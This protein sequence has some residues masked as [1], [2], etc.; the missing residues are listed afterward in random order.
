M[1]TL[2]QNPDLVRGEAARR[3]RE[4]LQ[5]VWNFLSGNRDAQFLIQGEHFT[6]RFKNG[7]IYMGTFTLD[8]T[9]KPKAI[10]MVITDGPEKHRGKVSLGIYALDGNHLIWCPSDPGSAERLGA[11]PADDDMKHL[12]IV[13]HREKHP[14]AAV[15][16]PHAGFA[17]S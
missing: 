11:F 4:K 7:P 2:V 9:R 5:G 14:A 17:A 15:Q 16:P 1:E 12:C 3:D 6:V 8:P 10:D 13:F